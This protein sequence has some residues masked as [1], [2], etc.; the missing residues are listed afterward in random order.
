MTFH[1][2]TNGQAQQQAFDKLKRRC[3]STPVLAIPSGQAELVLRTD[4]SREAMGVAL[5]QKDQYDY[6]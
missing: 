3:L 5:Y 1:P 2:S 4:A 6:L